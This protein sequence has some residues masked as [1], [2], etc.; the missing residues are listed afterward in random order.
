MIYTSRH[1]QNTIY[2]KGE[3]NY[4]TLYSETGLRDLRRI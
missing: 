3:K 4:G 1:P 2:I